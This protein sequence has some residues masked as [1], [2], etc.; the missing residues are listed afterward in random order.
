MRK[1]MAGAARA[2]GESLVHVS[3]G[4]LCAVAGCGGQPQPE[5]SELVG[6]PIINGLADPWPNDPS[7]VRIEGPNGGAS[8]TLVSPHVIL[9]AAHTINGGGSFTV[10]FGDDQSKPVATVTSSQSVQDPNYVMDTHNDTG[11][12]I[13]PSSSPHRRK[14]FPSR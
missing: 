2:R 13:L 10:Y 14:R 4:L 8:G 6:E 9:C 3:V 5:R 1:P 12:I 7:I 11:V